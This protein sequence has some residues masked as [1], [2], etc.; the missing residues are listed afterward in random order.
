MLAVV[1]I[2]ADERM[3]AIIVFD[4]DDIYAA[5]DELDARYMAGE[6]AAHADTWSAIA[7]VYAALNRG[8]IPATATDLEISTTDAQR[9]G[10][11][12]DGIPSGRVGISRHGA[13]FTSRPFIG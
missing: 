7:E 13:A 2:D 5:F 8:E 3:A 12:T 9:S 10:P 11:V 4:T 6:A 1:E